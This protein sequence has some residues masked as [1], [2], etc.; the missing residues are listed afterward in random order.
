[1]KRFQGS[2][3]IITGA[4][5]G[6]GASAAR[7]F[8]QEGASLVLAARR[9]G[10][11][12]ALAGELNQLGHTAHVVPTDV[13]DNAACQALIEQTT[14]LLGGVDILVNNAGAHFRGDFD[15]RSAEQFATMIDVNLRGPVVLTRHAI[16]AM[17][18]RGAIVNVASLAGRIPLPGAVVYSATKFGIRAF[19]LA[20]AEELRDSGI[21]VS[22]VSPGPVDTGF[23]MDELETVSPMALSQPMS[24]SEEIADLVL[25]AAFTGKP[26]YA[27]PR[28]GAFLTTLGYVLPP[29]AR[30]LRPFIQKRG[31]R[32]K[33]RLMRR[34]KG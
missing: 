1:M 2:R 23:I 28:S 27:K 6:I 29:V 22:L 31:E 30:A 7:K 12:E 3:V 20:L 26:E 5:A 13:A 18:G 4:S 10:P 25:A 17:R 32:V 14:A 8:A 19:S 34:N 33:E 15:A 11:L 9:P 21:T 24:T 16:D